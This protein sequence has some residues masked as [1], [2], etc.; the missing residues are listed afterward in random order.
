MIHKASTPYQKKVIYDKGKSA[1][2]EARTLDLR[3]S[4]PI[5]TYKYDALTDCAT[6]AKQEE[7]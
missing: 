4:S 6:R 5:L 1:L 2:G 3:I 7:E